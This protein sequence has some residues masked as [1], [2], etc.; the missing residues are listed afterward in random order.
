MGNSTL[1]VI[2]LSKN[3]ITEGS[4]ELI[5]EVV[6]RKSN[7]LEIYLHWNRISHKGS[8]LIFNQLQDNQSL[9]VFDIS[10]NNISGEV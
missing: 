10:W 1:K 2:N 4:C 3:I 8:D 9:K 7:I 6:Y 5:S